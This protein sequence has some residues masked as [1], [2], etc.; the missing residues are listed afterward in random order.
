MN[1]AIETATHP[2]GFGAAVRYW[3]LRRILYNVILCA[4]ALGWIVATWPHFLPAFAMSSVL[5]IGVLALL[6]NV[7]YCA[8][9][10]AEMLVQLSASAAARARWRLAIWI[11][12]TL[13]AVVLE[14]YWIGDEIY[15]YV[16]FVK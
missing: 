3:E 5:P 14:Y 13:L 1:P 2:E 16:P 15:P 9:Y 11:T 10:P 7:L 8:A 12:G 6:A 4:V